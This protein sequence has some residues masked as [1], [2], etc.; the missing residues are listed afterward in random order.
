MRRIA[1]WLAA[2]LLGMLPA[3]PAL[4]QSYVISLAIVEMMVEPDGAVLVTETLTYAFDGSFS[5]AYRDIPL[6]GGQRITDVSVSEEG[7]AYR[8]G[9]CTELGCTSPPR[10]MSR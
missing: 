7:V 8:P 1:A 10:G 2:L 5:G 4:A 6:G 3:G 9:G